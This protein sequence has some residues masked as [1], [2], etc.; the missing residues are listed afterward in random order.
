MLSIVRNI[1]ITLAAFGGVISCAHLMIESDK[2]KEAAFQA[3]LEQTRAECLADGETKWTCESVVQ[4]LVA[5]RAAGKAKDAAAAAMM[6]SG[7][8][9]GMA[10]G[11]R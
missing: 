9:A 11:R 10:A 3:K 5:T 1:A 8:A 2:K 7:V 4:A 6:A